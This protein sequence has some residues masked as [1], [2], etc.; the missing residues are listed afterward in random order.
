MLAEIPKVRQVPG[1][2][3]RRW[4]ADSSFDLILW[5]ADDSQAELLGF[6]LCYDKETV[7]RALTWYR[8][9]GFY[10]NRIDDGESSPFKNRTPILVADGSF[11]KEQVLRSFR[12]A[13]AQLD[14]KL[15][16]FILQTLEGYS[17]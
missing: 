11:P 3:F 4:F 17:G 16:S 12:A 8:G 15:V 9:K 1:D 13:A 2:G 5:Y 14:A 6:Q 10:H 7:Q